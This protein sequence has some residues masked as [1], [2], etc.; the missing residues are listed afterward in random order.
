[1]QLTLENVSE[2]FTYHPPT[3]E[4]RKQKHERVNKMS[5][6]LAQVIMQEVKDEDCRKMALFAIQQARMFANQGITV[7]EVF[8]TS[9]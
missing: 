6:E 4:E 7:D 1:M 9:N 2:F 3:T 8:G 5:L